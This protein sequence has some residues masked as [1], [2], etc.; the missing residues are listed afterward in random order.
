MTAPYASSVVDAS[1]WNEASCRVVGLI[2]HHEVGLNTLS[3]NLVSGIDASGVVDVILCSEGGARG[4][5]AGWVFRD[6]G[7]GWAL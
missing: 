6:H 2:V 4:N 7:G 1:P 3:V 5:F